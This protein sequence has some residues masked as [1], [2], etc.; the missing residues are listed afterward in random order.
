MLPERARPTS[1]YGADVV[2]AGG[3]T[4]SAS[5]RRGSTAVP[6]AAAV[7]IV[8]HDAARPLA[9]PALF[10]AVLAALADRQAARAPSAPCR[11]PTP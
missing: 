9:R 7:V 8:V 6:P 3:P 10:R 4:R 5:V 1:R 11:W 2:V